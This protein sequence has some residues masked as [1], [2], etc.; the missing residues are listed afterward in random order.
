MKA[1]C[2]DYEYYFSRTDVIAR[3]SLS[4]TAASTARN[5]LCWNGSMPKTV[6]RLILY[7]MKKE[8]RFI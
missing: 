1:L 7:R 3:R 6:S 4:G 8:N 5:L 2:I